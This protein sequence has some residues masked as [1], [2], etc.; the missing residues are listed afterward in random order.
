MHRATAVG[1]ISHG[2]R[3]YDD[4]FDKNKHGYK[5]KLLEVNITG[6]EEA[7]GAPLLDSQGGY[8]GMF[9]GK[10]KKKELSYFIAYPEIQ[11]FISS[12]AP[13]VSILQN[14]EIAEPK[15][16]SVSPVSIPQDKATAEPKSKYAK[17]R[18]GSEEM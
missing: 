4:V 1:Q 16:L 9:H 7:A 2:R 14:K 15:S 10:D 18:K 12:S 6:I 5:L 8:V 11:S 17:K 3:D 13:S